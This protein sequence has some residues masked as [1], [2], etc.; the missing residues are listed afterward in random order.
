MAVDMNAPLD[1][2]LATP[3]PATLKGLSAR[4]VDQPLSALGTLGL[5]L[6]DGDLP[7]P[8]AVLRS[9]ALDHNEAWMQRFVQRAGA[10][11]CPHGKTTM[12]PQLFQRQLQAGAW[13]ITAATASHVRTYRRFGVPRILLANQ[14]VGAANIGLVLDEL[15][16]DPAFDFYCLVDSLAGLAHLQ[17]V[18]ARRPP[19]R[20]LQVLL[21]VGAAGGRSGVR[22][23][24]EGLAL[25]RALRDAGPATACMRAWCTRSR[26]RPR[27]GAGATWASGAAGPSAGPSATSGSRSASTSGRCPTLCCFAAPCSSW[28]RPPPARTK[29]PRQA[30]ER[31]PGHTWRATRSQLPPRM[32]RTVSSA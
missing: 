29:R 24:D 31:R 21:E 15:A 18:F 9:S 28:W 16:A 12:A 14:L 2:L 8:A 32:P 7:L 26:S 23:F 13:G 4:A 3:L 22:S 6:H 10:S 17:Q 27:P 25:G 5:S 11:L 30:A 20:P 1:E 19:P